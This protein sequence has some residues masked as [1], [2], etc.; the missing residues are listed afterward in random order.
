MTKK[1]YD[2][3]DN[4]SD[5]AGISLEESGPSWEGEYSPLAENLTFRKA[6]DF[7]LLVLRRRRETLRRVIVE[8]R[9]EKEPK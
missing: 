2:V 1:L 4:L 9:K 5:F 7:K 3:I 8:T 6:R